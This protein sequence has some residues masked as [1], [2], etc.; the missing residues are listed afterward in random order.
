[1]SALKRWRNTRGFGVHSPFGYDIATRVVRPGRLY[2]YYGYEVINAACEREGCSG[3]VRKQAKMLLR[4]AVLLN[5]DSAFLPTGVHPAFHSALKA[6]NNRMHIE[7]K[8]KNAYSCRML[9]AKSDY[10]SLE[11]I[12]RHL[13]VSGNVIALLDVPEGWT[14][15]IYESMPH[16]IMVKGKKN[17]FFIAR[18]K[19]Q[20]VGYQMTI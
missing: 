1:M 18:D 13:S 7:R 2:T 12:K 15:E 14:E 4:L 5:I 6:A 19:M 3:K 10:L 16:G 20:K 11:E 9:C 8:L 17:V